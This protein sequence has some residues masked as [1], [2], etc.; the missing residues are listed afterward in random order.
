M[1]R[2]IASEKS[3]TKFLFNCAGCGQIHWF[4]TEGSPKWTFNGDF[5]RPT[6]SPSLLVTWPQSEGKRDGVCHF[7]VKDGQMQFL[8]DCTHGNAGKTLEM[9]D[10]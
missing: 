4:Q 7:F 6:L 1:A 3:G 5:E 2:K 9:P 8:G 10:W